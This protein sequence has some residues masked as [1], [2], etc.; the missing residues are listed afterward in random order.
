ME[1]HRDVT[2]NRTAA[3]DSVTTGG[4]QGMEQTMILI[5]LAAGA[6][7]FAVG[8]LVTAWLLLVLSVANRSANSPATP[9]A[10]Q[11]QAAGR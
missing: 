6:V 10:Q 3:R 7:G 1:R 11:R 2:E 5:A 9:P 8:G 4:K